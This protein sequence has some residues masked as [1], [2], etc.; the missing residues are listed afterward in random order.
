M[1][2]QRA[3]PPVLLNTKQCYF[4]AMERLSV[5]GVVTRLGPFLL[6][7]LVA[8]CHKQR[9]PFVRLTL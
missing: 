7:A 2:R 6:G 4:E 8:M 1:F 5:K 3:F 9:Q